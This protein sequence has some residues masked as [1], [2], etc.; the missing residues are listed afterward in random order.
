[1]PFVK[2]DA[3]GRIAAVTREPDDDAGERLNWN[4]RELLDFLF[5]DSDQDAVQRKLLLSDLG[6]LRVVEDLIELLVAKQ[7][8]AWTDLPAAAQDKMLER[9]SMRRFLTTSAGMAMP[10]DEEDDAPLL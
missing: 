9:R 7:L 6:M 5:E 4:S 1:M 2:R 8:I 3:D 10:E